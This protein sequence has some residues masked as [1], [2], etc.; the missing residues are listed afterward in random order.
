VPAP[1]PLPTY[2]RHYSGERY[3][4]A[5]Q[6]PDLHGRNYRYQPRSDV[7]RQQYPPQAPHPSAKRAQPEPQR[8]K[9]Q[10][11]A[12]DKREDGNQGQGK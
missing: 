7:V 10:G 2:Q 11:H 9:G 12:K 6:Q 3:P 4:R 8:G 5:E 1:A